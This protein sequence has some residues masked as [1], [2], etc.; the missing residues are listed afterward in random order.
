MALYPPPW[1]YYP[2]DVAEHILQRISEGEYLD[3]ILREPGMP[4]R[5]TVMR[6]K[7][8]NPKFAVEQRIG[9]LGH[10]CASAFAP[11]IQTITAQ[12]GNPDGASAWRSSPMRS[13][14]LTHV[15]DVFRPPMRLGRPNAARPRNTVFYR[16]NLVNFSPENVLSR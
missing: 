13:E 2:P 1:G 3:A 16:T 6:W 8:K 12:P 4:D 7:N 14:R 10:I 5:R 11:T 15:L 9:H